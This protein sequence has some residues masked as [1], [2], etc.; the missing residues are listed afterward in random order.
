[1]ST[2]A[3]CTCNGCS[4][5]ESAPPPDSADTADTAG[6]VSAAPEQSASAQE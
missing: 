1:M 4:K 6:D 2:F 5:G 3:A